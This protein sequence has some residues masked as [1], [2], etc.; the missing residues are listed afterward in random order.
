[1]WN[2]NWYSVSAIASSAMVLVTSIS[3]LIN[4]SQNRKNR[5]RNDMQNERNR[6]M[7]LRGLKYQAKFNWI[8]MLRKAIVEAENYLDFAIADKFSS[9]K[10][11][12]RSYFND[13]VR[14]AFC[15][16]NNAKRC[17][18]AVLYGCGEYEE[19]FLLFF[20]N[21]T[22]HYLDWVFDL[23]FF[24]TLKWD[25]AK[26]IQANIADYKLRHQ[27]GNDNSIGIWTLIE[28]RNF[29]K[30]EED[31]TYYINQLNRSYRY[32]QLEQECL[33]LLNY[34]IT[35]ANNIL[36]GTEQDK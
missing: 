25:D 29:G 15:N 34:E 5:L 7:Q 17:L 14:E 9:N 4:L 13:I 36:N 21:F 19:R 2:I 28:K 8:T 22:K 16:S 23:E 32:E 27:R 6:D 1:M 18:S 30:T 33:K 11:G 20:N 12:E 35:L 24:H 26:A 31:L 3:I 10:F